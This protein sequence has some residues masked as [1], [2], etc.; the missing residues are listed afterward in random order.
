MKRQYVAFLVLAVLL[1]AGCGGPA[2]D[3]ANPEA[4]AR[5]AAEAWMRSDVDALIKVSCKHMKKQ[6]EATRAS[7]EE[8][9]EM[10]RSM[11]VDMKDIRFDFSKVTFTVT[12]QE[13]FSAKVHMAGPL[14]VSI[15]GRSPDVA[16]QDMELSLISEGG[17][18]K[19]CSELN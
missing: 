14:T 8:M 2:M 18:W 13:E 4:V 7:R 12:E 6:L 3:N 5:A 10:M 11:G 1:V 15:P 19:L 16:E 17:Q 9:A